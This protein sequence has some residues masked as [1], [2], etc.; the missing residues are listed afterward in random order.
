V[1]LELARTRPVDAEVTTVVR[2]HCKLVDHEPLIRGLEKLDRE[3]PCD[4]EILRN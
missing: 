1:L 4:T 2:A 3:N